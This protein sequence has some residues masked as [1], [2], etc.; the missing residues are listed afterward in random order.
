MFQGASLS[1]DAM[2][3]A[4]G[5]IN[6]YIDNHGSDSFVELNINVG[7]EVEKAATEKLNGELQKG[8]ESAEEFG[9]I[10]AEDVRKHLGLSDF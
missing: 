6:E 2:I 8:F 10:D 7:E 1:I 9:W 3:C 4:L 5:A